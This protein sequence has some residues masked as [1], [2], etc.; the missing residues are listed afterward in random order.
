[1]IGFLSILVLLVGIGAMSVLGFQEKL[2][3]FERYQNVSD[4]TLRLATAERDYVAM[5]RN[6]YAYIDTGDAAYVAR[7]RELAAGVAKELGLA[8]GEAEV[9]RLRRDIRDLGA[10]IAD[11]SA[12]FD[13]LVQLRQAQDRLI[14]ERLNPTGSAALQKLADVQASVAAD[15]D[16]EITAAAARAATTVLRARVDVYRYL[17]ASDP[18][19]AQNARAGFAAFLAESEALVRLLPNAERRRPALDA[20]EAVKAYAAAFDELSASLAETRR[21]T[22]QVMNGLADRAARQFSELTTAQTRAMTEIS[23]ATA[24]SVRMSITKTAVSGAVAV[25]LGLLLAWLIGSG[26]AN[27]VVAMTG[28]MGRLAAG[29]TSITV[30]SRGR[31]DEIGQMAGA[32]QVFKDNMIEAER[33]RREQETLKQRAE[34]EKRATMN[35]MADEFEESVKGVVEIVSS[36]STELQSTAQAMSATAEETSRQSAAVAA[37]AE[38]AS[39][40]VQTVASATEELS[41]SISEIGKQVSESS[42]ITTRAVEEAGRTN[43]KIRELAEA[44][45]KI[46]DV[47]KLINDIAGQTN[48][49]ALNATIEAARAG[50]AGKG[51]AVVASEVKSLATQTA[52]AT[53]E[54]SSKI[55]EMQQVTGESVSAIESIGTTIARIN[56]IATSIASAVEQ[57]GAATQEIARNVQQASAGTSDVSSN[58]VSVTKAAG[59]TGAAATQVLSSSGELSKQS[60]TLRGE[61]DRFITRIRAA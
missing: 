30:P 15:R 43:A 56:D 21:L 51:F 60:E 28:V 23:V 1:M 18:S 13:K 2:S 16:F 33:L 46:G 55:L 5:R 61:V 49:L 3:E 8:A 14:A 52:K 41:A 37:A 38:Q 34:A 22:D 9:E 48:L 40:N 58:I 20:A 42:R 59:D 17:A 31:R 19:L 26:T 54:I 45:Q 12:N 7:F 11:Y 47:V 10:I 4:N 27:P 25:V 32:V 53:D 44:A 6:G 39:T 57:Q 29:D 24:G 35:R 50:E 36:A